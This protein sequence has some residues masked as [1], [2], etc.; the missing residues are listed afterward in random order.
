MATM[1]FNDC[2]REGRA[3][4]LTHGVT[5]LNKHGY[6]PGTVQRAGFLAGFSSAHREAQERALDEA[7]AYHQLSVR[8]AEKDRAWAEKLAARL[9]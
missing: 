4:F 6:D 7:R 2:A 9:P 5:G 8:D 1:S 3:A